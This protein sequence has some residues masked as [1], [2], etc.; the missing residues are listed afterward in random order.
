MTSSGNIYRRLRTILDASHCQ[1]T[2]R[3]GI[4]GNF[5]FSHLSMNL[6]EFATSERIEIISAYSAMELMLFA[7]ADKT[8]MFIEVELQL[9][10]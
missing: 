9:M 10:V 1:V 6:D 2:R 7:I 5:V 3:R 8:V 4:V